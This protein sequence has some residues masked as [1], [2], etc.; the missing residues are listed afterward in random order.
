MSP[1]DRHEDGTRS[2]ERGER[3]TASRVTEWMK[4]AYH[5]SRLSSGSSRFV[6]H[7]SPFFRLVCS[8]PSE[9][10][11]RMSG[12]T[13]ER[14][15]RRSVAGTLVTTSVSL[16]S[17]RYIFAS[18]VPASPFPPYR[19]E[20]WV[21]WS[22]KRSETKNRVNERP[23]GNGRERQWDTRGRSLT[24]LGS[25]ILLTCLTFSSHSIRSVSRRRWEVRKWRMNDRT[26]SR[27][28]ERI[29]HEVETADGRY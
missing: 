5:I 24:R 16:S 4:L 7:S 15:E 6:S 3:W 13:K 19:R 17:T 20:K 18:R 11:A 10:E 22:D 1:R 29:D 28:G 12:G 25:F 8:S 2:G 26:S 14:S 23:T 9:P 21:R 27:Q